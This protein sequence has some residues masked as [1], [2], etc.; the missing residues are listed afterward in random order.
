VESWILGLADAYL[1]VAEQVLLQAR[2]PLRPREI[3]NIAYANEMLPWHLH[4]FTQHKTLHA[5]MSEDVATSPTSSRFFRT[6]PG[7]FFLRTFLDDPLVP[8]AFKNPYF[9]PP[10]RKELR[11]ERVLTLDGLVEPP[12]SK[13]S[14][15]V[16]INRLAKEFDQGRYR[17]I[18]PSEMMGRP[19]SVAVHSFVLVFHENTVLSY[20]CGKFFPDS[21]PLKG[22]RSIGIGGPVYAG[23]PDMLFHD[24][25]GI[26]AS[27]INELGYGIGLTKELSE[28]ARYNGEMKPC[29]GVQHAFAGSGSRVIHVVLAYECPTDFLPSK[30]AL[31]V[32]D[33]RWLQI[34]NPANTL[35]SFDF[36]SS[37]LFKT[38]RLASIRRAMRTHANG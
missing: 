29:V 14:D 22:K 17:F 32:N 25:F 28:R 11:R 18:T 1:N 24:M 9:A 30:A 15:F 8:E 16:T 10:R 34:D 7:V 6:G 20:R 3:I 33:L 21:A 4:G 31:S 26:I 35:E 19:E 5:R 27:G 36:T 23:D 37:L 38:G 2:R 12:G 13:P